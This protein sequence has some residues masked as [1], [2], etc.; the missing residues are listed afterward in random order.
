MLL[1]VIEIVVPL[2]VSIH[3]SLSEKKQF[4]TVFWNLE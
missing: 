1:N 4:S 2:C 3:E